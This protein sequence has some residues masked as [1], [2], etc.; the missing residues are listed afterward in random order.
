MKLNY[1]QSSMDNSIEINQGDI[2]ENFFSTDDFNFFK[3]SIKEYL[4]NYKDFYRYRKKC[5]RCLLLD[6]IILHKDLL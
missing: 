3:R 2:I 6:P 1:L 4:K 5:F